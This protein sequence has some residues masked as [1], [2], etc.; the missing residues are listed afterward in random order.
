MTTAKTRVLF[1]CTHNSARSQMA[2]GLM[3]GLL[4]YRFQAFSAGTVA[5]KVNPYVVRAMSEIDIDLSSHYSKTVNEFLSAEFEYIITVCD[6][7]KEVC[8]YF[9]GGKHVL[10]HSF[11]DPSAFT[12]TDEEIMHGIRAVRDEIKAWL[13]ETFDKR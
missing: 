11:P 9:P 6:N 2:E 8:P 4:G 3:N 10:H 5:T 1:L 12:G 7:A 13:I